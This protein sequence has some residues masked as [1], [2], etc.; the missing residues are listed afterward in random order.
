MSYSNRARRIW[1]QTDPIR[2]AQ[3][4]ASPAM[5][6][7]ATPKAGRAALAGRGKYHDSYSTSYMGT[8]AAVV[9]HEGSRGGPVGS[10]T[11]MNYPVAEIA[12]ADKEQCAIGDIACLER[13]MMRSMPGP[14]STG[15]G[16]TG[17][18]GSVA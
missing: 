7:Q 13:N 6:P 5:M 9:T 1:D 10:P 3:M 14:Y 11:D 4:S 12:S 15:G 17:G 18:F 8:P 2:Y 16:N